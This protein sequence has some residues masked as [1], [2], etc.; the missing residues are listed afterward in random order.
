[1]EE[2]EL[3]DATGTVA[4]RFSLEGAEVGVSLNR[5]FDRDGASAPAHHDRLNRQALASSPGLRMDGS[6]FRMT[7]PEA[8]LSINELL[9]NPVGTDAGQ[10]FVEL[11]NAG[12]TPLDLEGYTLCD[13]SGVCHTFGRPPCCP[14]RWW[15]SLTKEITPMWKG[16]CSPSPVV[17]RSTTRVTPSP[18][19][20]SGERC[21]MWP[22]GAP[23][24][25]A[26]PGTAPMMVGWI[27]GGA[28]TM[29]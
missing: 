18:S 15:C 2:L 22:A 25:R 11:V 7:A 6:S 3:V 17:S 26:S 16:R 19:R 12:D 13:E 29:R 8:Y 1:V 23:V 5:V 20:M 4:D 24:P 9:P 27:P 10:E 14:I 28:F 21:T